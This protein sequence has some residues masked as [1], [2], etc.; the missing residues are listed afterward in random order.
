MSGDDELLAATVE[1]IARLNRRHGP[2]PD[3]GER[4]LL[5]HRRRSWNESERKW[6][7]WERKRGKL[8]E[9][10]RLLRGATDTTFLS[11]GDQASRAPS[12]VRYV[13]T[14]DAD[15]QLPGGAACRLVGTMAH[16]LNRPQFEP[17]VGRVIE[18]RC[19]TAASHA[20]VPYGSRQ[21]AISESLLGPLWH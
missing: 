10:N 15:T 9:L 11:M 17:R 18:G 5:F 8:H 21:F 12:G 1:G 2:A 19:T 20:D 7:G 4:F 13:I 16:P 3:G 6:I 14:L